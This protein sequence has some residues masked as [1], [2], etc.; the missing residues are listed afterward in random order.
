[1]LLWEKGRWSEP[2]LLRGP[3]GLTG[4]LAFPAPDTLV[5]VS[6]D[7]SARWW[8]V[9]PPVEPSLFPND[10]TG[11]HVWRPVWS[12]D[13]SLV[14]L[15]AH[16]GINSEDR[17]TRG[18]LW[19][20]ARKAPR[21]TW[22]EIG[23]AFSQ[24]SRRVLT[25]EN[26]RIYRER[27][28]TSGAELRR[29]TLDRDGGLRLPRVSPDWRW[30]VQ[31]HAPGEGTLYQLATGKAVAALDGGSDAA[32]SPD[33]R[34]LAREVDRHLV[35]RDLATGNERRTDV[36]CHLAI[37]WSPDGR[38]LAT[39]DDSVVHLVEAA[40]GR[41]SA[42]LPGTGARLGVMLYLP[43]G[44]TLLTTGE[45]GA[46]RLWNRPTLRETITLA[47]MDGGAFYCAVS[48]DGRTIL[49]GGARGY[50]FFTVAP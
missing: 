49:A 36:P 39:R 16:F 28:T 31:W 30:I 46:V 47:T 45:D 35:L 34:T 3:M 20:V 19:D 32:F 4:G 21:F 15:A 24:D 40:T 18:V 48:P 29:F 8:T 14:T 6:A 33:S 7:A 17:K 42:Q 38:E 43:D 10:M 26:H 22:D 25:V 11:S 41:E 1:M 50:R 23:V 12:P 2:A 9:P 5:T 13:G 37:A 27:D 44:R